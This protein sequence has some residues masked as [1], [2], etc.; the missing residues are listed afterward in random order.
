M[1]LPTDLYR[2]P[3]YKLR[4]KVKKIG[5]VDVS[6]I[7]GLLQTK[8]RDEWLENSLRQ[9][10][11]RVH[12]DTESLVLKWCENTGTDTPV[13]TTRHYVD[14]EPL[15]KPALDQIQDTYRYERPVIRKAMFAKL[16]AG[17]L[18]PEHADGAIALRMVHR[19]HVPIVTNDQVHFFIDDTDFHMQAGEIIE[20]DNTRFHS[21]RNDSAV[22]RI[23]LIVD[24]YHA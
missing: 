11:F 16:K 5:T 3:P 18:I 12:Q 14:F 15:I 20:I 8:T 19:I 6:A 4:D 24:Y 23:H 7:N 13:E 2:A 10:K 21:V 1:N 9:Q 22:D 17:G